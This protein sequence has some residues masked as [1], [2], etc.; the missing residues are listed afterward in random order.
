VIDLS[1]HLLDL[2]Q[3]SVRAD[4]ENIVLSIC[5]SAEDDHI[6]ITIADDGKGMSEDE[7]KLAFDPFY[8][9]KPDKRIGLGLPLAFQA[10]KM[11]GGHASIESSQGKGTVIKIWWQL[12]HVDRQPLG[13]IVATVISFMA[14][15]P[16]VALVLEYKGMSGE[17]RFCTSDLMKSE[18]NRSLGQIGML[19]VAEDKLR[20]GLAR[21][22]FRPDRGGSNL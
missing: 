22:G 14:A 4:A 2:L 3:N 10:A 15:N 9:S 11:A 7:K 18:K 8:T 17:F 1:L 6:S 19:C 5:E 12:S 16:G 13:D 20:D 21:A